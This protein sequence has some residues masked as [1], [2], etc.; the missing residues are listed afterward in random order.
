MYWKSETRKVKSETGVFWRLTFHV[1][2]KEA[3]T[4]TVIIN[5]AA[6]RRNEPPPVQSKTNWQHAV[7]FI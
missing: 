3:I 4:W 7:S 6:D 1:S 2:L 5:Q